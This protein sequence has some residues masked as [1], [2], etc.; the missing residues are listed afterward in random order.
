MRRRRRAIRVWSRRY[1]CGSALNCSSS[2]GC[3]TDTLFRHVLPSRQPRLLQ[4]SSR[5]RGP[6]GPCYSSHC[7]PK[8]KLGH[9][10]ARS[11]LTGSRSPEASRRHVRSFR[12]TGSKVRPPNSAK[13]PKTGPARLCSGGFCGDCCL[14]CSQLRLRSSLRSSSTSLN[15]ISP[16]CRSFARPPPCRAHARRRIGARCRA[17][18][19]HSGR[20]RGSA[21]TC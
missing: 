20:N 14:H 8:L 13:Y 2:S 18:R 15:A 11:A 6:G 1:R 10:F 9:L 12:R 4:S 7:G 17:P 19:S 16:K 5:K 21:D 3:K